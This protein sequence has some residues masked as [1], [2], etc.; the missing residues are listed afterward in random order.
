MKKGIILVTAYVLIVLLPVVL[1]LLT[2]PGG[3][4]FLIHAGKNLGLTAFVILI[5]QAVL[6][7]RF[8]W[9]SRPFGFDIVIRYH[10]NI[11][12]FAGIILILHPL[13]IIAGS[14]DWS[15]LWSGGP[16]IWMGKIALALVIINV[17]TS[18]FQMKINLKF[19][20]WRVF[21]DILG[22]ALLVLAFVHSWNV[23]G[24][25]QTAPM[26]NL[27]IVFLGTA[28]L[29][30]VYHRF[31]RPWRLSRHPYEVTEVKTEAENV[32]TVKMTPGEGQ[33]RF[34]FIPGQFQFI[35]FLRNRGL[36]E[37]EHHFTISSSPTQEG[38]VAAT[39][40]ALGDFTAT[41]GET[42]PGDRA[43]IHA[44]FG[45]F[46]HLF[47]PEEAKLVF[48]AG[49]V[50]ITPL[51]SMLRYMRDKK[52]SKQVTL[53]YGS[54]NRKATVFY[55]ELREMERSNHPSLQFIPVLEKPEEGWEGESGFIDRDK[56]KKYVDTSNDKT[57]FYVV[58]PPPLLYKSIDNLHA[59]GI[60]DKRIHMEI[61][62]FL[63]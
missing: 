63:D 44:P 45:R 9:M 12:I 42:R 40:K 47:H 37:E 11:S 57:G 43:V 31:I 18:V 24:D 53:F 59:L 49:G 6:A 5:L 52:D 3:Q 35:K 60:K 14:G 33:K 61:F 55:E 2:G 23:G 56:I 17:L 32:W 19:E 4:G 50:G 28:V 38:F 39:I 13:L 36:P 21:H 48:I 30:F 41:V 1:A 51:M 8:K 10:R 62:S 29:V 58:G 20:R 46:S 34:D 15:L 22:P 54:L 25:L 27:W 26:R 16:F 7:A